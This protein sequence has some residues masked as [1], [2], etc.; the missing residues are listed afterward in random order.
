MCVCGGGGDSRIQFRHQLAGARRS[1]G[2]AY[3]TG[4]P[5]LGSP[6]KV[7]AGPDLWA[8]LGSARLRTFLNDN[9]RPFSRIAPEAAGCAIK[10]P[11]QFLQ[12]G[13]RKHGLEGR[14]KN[15]LLPL[16]PP[17]GIFDI[18][19]V[20]AEQTPDGARLSARGQTHFGLK[21]ATR[22]DDR[23]CP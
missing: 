2:R 7:P 4:P 17:S 18:T 10:R 8:P 9:G 13:E 1:S 19:S 15:F 5:R 11:L 16:G 14:G 23:K 3:F 20:W 22:L 12:T 21:W 6:V